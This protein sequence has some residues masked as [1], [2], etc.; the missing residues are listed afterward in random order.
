MK[1]TAAARYALRALAYLAA[2]DGSPTVTSHDVARA[3][4]IPEKY[5]LK[6]FRLLVTAGVLHSLKGPNGGYHL[7]QPAKAVT[8]LE[9][10]EAVDGPLRGLAPAVEAADG[11][12][13]D[14]QLAA[15]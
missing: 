12:Q 1:T 6:V 9:I 3:C 14:R 13:L 15:I 8:L 4:G 2:P 7:A 10:V 5:L 11:G